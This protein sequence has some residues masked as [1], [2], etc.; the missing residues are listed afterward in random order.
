MAGADVGEIADAMAALGAL[1]DDRLS[2]AV[3]MAAVPGDRA[4]CEQAAEAAGRICELMA[5]GDGDTRL[6]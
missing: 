4:A 1:L 2:R 5:C 6:R 3:S